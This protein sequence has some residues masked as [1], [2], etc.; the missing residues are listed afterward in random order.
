[1]ERMIKGV[2]G[3]MNLCCRAGARGRNENNL[4]RSL[5]GAVGSHLI[6]SRGATLPEREWVE[7]LRKVCTEDLAIHKMSLTRALFLP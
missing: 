4:S 5:A 3:G 2:C 6:D 1:M 7:I